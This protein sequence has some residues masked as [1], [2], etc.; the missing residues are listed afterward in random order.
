MTYNPNCLYKLAKVLPD[1]TRESVI[2]ECWAKA[3]KEKPELP[4]LVTAVDL[5]SNIARWSI[6]R[7]R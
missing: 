3:I 7:A 2:E 4:G 1:R 5:L 6:I